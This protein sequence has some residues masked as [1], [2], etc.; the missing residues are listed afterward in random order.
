MV[1]LSLPSLR[2]SILSD[3]SCRKADFLEAAVGEL[4]SHVNKV[5]L[6]PGHFAL[7]APPSLSC[8]PCWIHWS[9]G[10]PA[11]AFT[12]CCHTA[13]FNLGCC[14]HP[15]TKARSSSCEG[16]GNCRLRQVPHGAQL[17]RLESFARRD[18]LKELL[19][20][21]LANL[22]CWAKIWGTQTCVFL[23][24]CLEI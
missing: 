5:N 6:V 18:S 2:N 4:M 11:C 3:L 7:G 24:S 10:R 16:E 8:C 23:R 12:S 22:A 15:L 20:A 9:S 21:I 1:G 17:C 14:L 19:Q 13:I